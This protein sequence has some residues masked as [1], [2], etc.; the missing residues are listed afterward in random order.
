MSRN[1]E[2]TAREVLERLY[3][4]A[5]TRHTIIRCLARS[6]RFASEVRPDGWS[7]TLY[8]NL[9]RL[10]V[11]WVELVVLSAQ[12][13]FFT[14]SPTGPMAAVDGASY[15]GAG[16]RDLGEESQRV[17]CA[18]RDFGRVYEA[19]FAEHSEAIRRA[20]RRRPPPQA[21]GAHS[22]G[23]LR[24]MRTELEEELPEADR[25]SVAASAADLAP[26]IEEGRR[27]YSWGEPG[28]LSDL[29]QQCIYTIAK[30]SDLRES[31][32]E[33][34]TVN[35]WWAE[36]KRLFEAAQREG[37]RLPVLFADA[38]E[39]C[40]RLFGWALLD[41]VE[42]VDTHTRFRFSDW[43]PLSNASTQELIL[44]KTGEPIAD[45]F[46]RPYALCATPWF[47]RYN[48]AVHPVERTVRAWVVKG[49]PSR[50]NLDEMIQP[51][52]EEEWIT[53][54]PPKDWAPGDAVFLWKSSPELRL[55]GFGRIVATSTAR[56]PHEDTAFMLEYLAGPVSHP[57]GLRELRQDPVLGDAS[58]LKSGPA[59]TVFPL[60]PDQS[61]QLARLLLKR[62]PSC[63]TAFEDHLFGLGGL[64]VESAKRDGFGYNDILVDPNDLELF[65]AH[66]GR[67]ILA[68]HYARERNQDLRNLA[69][70]LHRER[71]EGLRCTVCRFDFAEV[72]GELGA[73]FA[74]VH[75]ARPLS[76]Y[77]AM[78]AQTSVE[79]LVVVC[80]NCH[81]MLHRR[82]PWLTAAA[83][84][85]QLR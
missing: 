4:D 30:P 53:A 2:V 54:K 9:V 47:I 58:F 7:V 3:P 43:R 64:G 36:G 15:E 61:T 24:Y 20:A 40:S 57:L 71:T 75:H 51:H 50:N 12:S 1:D 76:E 27:P 48:R 79:D 17:R 84:K 11:G 35:Q 18:P 8:S 25:S 68:V 21:R 5:Q 28:Q 52:K 32:N 45:G 39:D 62:N 69:K 81:R 80:A 77:E 67:K 78:G 66:E 6:I 59:G 37:R 70:K 23:V 26:E 42:K 56:N 85:S 72:Y 46:I 55:A 83:L 60:T 16:Y 82:R 38:A 41:E 10:N 73:D 29:A 14:V 13:T 33:P 63:Q 44:L 49:R 74:E 65:E 34:R 31:L 19:R 22:P